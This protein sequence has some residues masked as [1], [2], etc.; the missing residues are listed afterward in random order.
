MLVSTGVT[1][2]LRTTQETVYSPEQPVEELLEAI[3]ARD[4]DRAAELLGVESSLIT[5]AALEEGYT[6]PT[7][8]RITKSEYGNPEEGLNYLATEDPDRRPER[9]VGAVYVEYTVNGTEHSTRFLVQREKTGMLRGWEIG[10][11]RPEHIGEIKIVSQHIPF[12]KVASRSGIPAASSHLSLAAPEPLRALPGTYDISIEE[13]N[14]LF[15]Q[16]VVGEL[17]VTTQSSVAQGR[18]T[19]TFELDDL[20]VRPDVVDQVESQIDSYL[21][22]CEASTDPLPSPCPFRFTQGGVFKQIDTVEWTILKRPKVQVKPA[23][24]DV[25]YSSPISVETVSEGKVEVTA[26]FQRE[27]YEPKTETMD[28]SVGGSADISE[29]GDVEWKVR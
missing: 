18:G 25:A 23:G 10:A 8:M 24:D 26:T 20:E 3:A 13:E 9:D 1:A 5:S 6:P 14:E 2:G 16:G 17:E 12:V 19:A 27:Y 28:F 22:E 11:P 7:G 15:G 21:D 4:G 29:D